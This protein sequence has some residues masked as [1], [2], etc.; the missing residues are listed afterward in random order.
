MVLALDLGVSGHDRID[1]VFRADA[2]QIFW[3]GA[4]SGQ[5]ERV[6]HEPGV[7]QPLVHRAQV[8]LG[9]AQA[10]NEKDCGLT[11]VSAAWSC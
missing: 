6:G 8:V 11:H 7:F 3:A 1:P 2:R 10:V 9:A 4:M 5:G